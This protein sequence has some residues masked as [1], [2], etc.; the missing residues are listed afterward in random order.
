M[1]FIVKS[2]CAHACYTVKYVFT[3][4]FT[5]LYCSY[6]AAADCSHSLSP[7]ACREV[8][9]YVTAVNLLDIVSRDVHCLRYVLAPATNSVNI[10]GVCVFPWPC[11]CGCASYTVVCCSEIRRYF[12][13]VLL[14]R[15]YSCVLY[16]AVWCH[17]VDAC[18]TVI[19]N[20]YPAFSAVWW[21]RTCIA[22]FILLSNTVTTFLMFVV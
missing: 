10:D 3:D 15:L 14:P 21:H 7:S 8:T 13:V 17:G 6:F 9:V 1:K 5:T 11:C 18:S 12:H 2:N 20:A 19:H 22:C 16:C 4:V